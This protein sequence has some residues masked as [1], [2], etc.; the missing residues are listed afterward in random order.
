LNQINFIHENTLASLGNLNYLSIDSNQ[1]KVLNK[2]LFRDLI[3]LT[4]D[5][6]LMSNK[7]EIIKSGTFNDLVKLVKIG[8]SQNLLN[9]I[10]KYSFQNLPSLDLLDLSH[11][12]F[13]NYR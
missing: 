11:D 8:L 13:S 9:K 12:Y 7:I 2:D 6:D 5:L 1:I 3:G 10:E 4:S